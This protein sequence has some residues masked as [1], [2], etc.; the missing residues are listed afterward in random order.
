M[1]AESPPPPVAH[2][3]TLAVSVPD[4]PRKDPSKK[5]MVLGA[6]AVPSVVILIAAVAISRGE[7]RGTGRVVQ[8]ASAAPTSHETDA[9]KKPVVAPLRSASVSVSAAPSAST[10]PSEWPILSPFIEPSAKPKHPPPA[11]EVLRAAQSKLDDAMRKRDIRGGFKALKELVAIAPDSLRDK[12]IRT[13]AVTL[14]QTL[15]LIQGPEPAEFLTLLTSDWAP[16]GLDVLYEIVATRGSS[17]AA[18]DAA[19]FLADET[20]RARGTPALRIAWEMRAA[21]SCDAKRPL[22]GRAAAEGDGRVLSE[23]LIAQT[24]CRRGGICCAW[25]EPA[26]EETIRALRTKPKP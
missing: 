15:A 6:A 21:Q 4:L 22:L 19:I 13:H 24:S 26:V 17:R 9:P 20:V 2:A 1:S 25:K 18:K 23:L 7:Y 14:S 5:L 11:P 3:R 10:D 16:D 8:T 12:A